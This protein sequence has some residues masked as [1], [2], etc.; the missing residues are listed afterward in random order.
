VLAYAR[1]EAKLP[2][3]IEALAENGHEFI[4]I[5]RRT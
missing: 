3:L 2:F 5:L 4:A 1:D